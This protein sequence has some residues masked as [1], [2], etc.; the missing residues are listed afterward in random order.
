MFSLHRL[1]FYV[2]VRDCDHGRVDK[3]LPDGLL[4]Q[5]VRLQVDCCRR[6]VQNW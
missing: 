4:D 2:P 5:V 1:R 3:L 6:F